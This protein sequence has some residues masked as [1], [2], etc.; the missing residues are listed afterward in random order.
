MNKSSNNFIF[1]M[2]LAGWLVIAVSLGSTCIP[3]RAVEVAPNA[4]HVE[5]RAVDIEPG[6]VD[7]DFEPDVRVPIAS[8]TPQA[9]GGSSSNATKAVVSRV[10]QTSLKDVKDSVVQ[11]GVPPS[12]QVAVGICG[13]VLG[14]A[15]LMVLLYQFKQMAILRDSRFPRQSADGKLQ[16]FG[17]DLT[18]G[19]F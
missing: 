19:G 1:G 5:P 18:G 13:T 6:A 15:V 11:Y 8:D 9:K 4:V 3:E 2:A 14:F 12:V 17:G 16:N 10:D 7:V